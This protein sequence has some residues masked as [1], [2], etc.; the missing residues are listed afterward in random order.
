MLTFNALG[1]PSFRIGAV[2]GFGLRPYETLNGIEIIRFK[3]SSFAPIGFQFSLPLTRYLAKSKVDIVHLQGFF[4]LP[5]VILNAG[6][7][8]IVHK[9]TI[10]TTHA[11]H[12]TLSMLSEVYH[13][14]LRSLG[15]R[16][17][18]AFLNSITYFIALSNIDVV[19]LT[20]LGV[21][22]RKI[23]HIP[24]GID[25]EKFKS[26]KLTTNV[27]EKYQINSDTQIILCVSRIARNKGI[28]NFIVAA[29]EVTKKFDN[30]IFI[31]VGKTFDELYKREL[32]K[33]LKK[34]KLTK[35][36]IFTDHISDHELINLYN[37]SRMMVL[38]SLK[39]TL[40]LV[41]L[42]AMAVGCPVI[43]TSVGGIPEMISNEENGI[44]VKPNNPEE[45]A[46]WII[47]LLEN[48]NL[49][50]A[51]VKKSQE[52]VK[53]YSWKEVA[54]KTLEVYHSAREQIYD[55]EKSLSAR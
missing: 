47:K 39:E 11:L 19:A 13:S 53:R 40:P 46:K 51:I 37:V 9:P 30:L 10:L 20:K 32:T 22:L 4:K 54:K 55:D 33:L 50:H 24:N 17:L 42:E 45:I 15:T 49:V 18:K 23:R 12:E 21:D 27:L 8:R 44:L 34:L 28:H 5:N 41:I 3:Y 29:S 38:P 1:Q 48:Q 6:A 43:A 16:T 7:C 31:V 52:N 14:S 36:F 26:C 2:R 35:Q 25:L